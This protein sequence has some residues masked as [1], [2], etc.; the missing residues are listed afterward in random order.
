MILKQQSPSRKMYHIGKRPMASREPSAPKEPSISKE[1]V[2]DLVPYTNKRP[3][4]TWIDPC[5][6]D[7]YISLPGRWMTLT[8][9]E[10]YRRSYVALHTLHAYS[11]MEISCA[12]HI[13]TLSHDFHLPRMKRIL[14]ILMALT[15]PSPYKENPCIPGI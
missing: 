14:K 11:Y 15:P 13:K 12:T 5:K 6:V 8:D 7:G 4:V 2:Q 10:A 1:F 3:M 9:R